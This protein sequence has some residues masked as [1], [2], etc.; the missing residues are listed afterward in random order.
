[1]TGAELV[2]IQPPD[3]KFTFELLKQSSCSVYLTNVTDQYVAF[4][5]KTTSPKKY[6]VKPNI[7]IIKPKSTVDFT[8]IMQAQRTAPV[9]MQCK[10]KF[11]VQSTFIP[12]GKIEDEITPN[13]FLKDEGKYIQENKLRVF[14]I[15][16]PLPPVLQPFNVLKEDSPDNSSTLKEKLLIGLE[17]FPPHTHIEKNEDTK[18]GASKDEPRLGKS[19]EVEIRRDEV[20]E[21]I[22]VEAIETTEV[23]FSKNFEEMK[24]KLGVESTTVD[25]LE[26]KEATFSK[27]FEE[28][29]ANLG[30]NPDYVEHMETTQVTLSKNRDVISPVQTD[31]GDVEP[32]SVEYP[33]ELK[34]KF[35]VEPKS[36]ENVGTAQVL[37]SKNPEEL[38]AKFVAGLRSAEDAETTKLMLSKDIEE[39]KEKLGALNSKLIEAGHTISKL[40]QEKEA[41]A[42]E[43][44]TLMREMVFARKKSGVRKV[45]VGFPPLFV[46]MV[47]LVGLAVGFL[48]RA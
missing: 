47:A 43:K 23:T 39:L 9:D 19:M 45:Q 12:Y 27:P 48:L 37:L 6:C 42:R 18:I 13:M 29:K 32:R 5:V 26:R 1:M 25:D 31:H 15:S 8:V 7:G 14:L 34:A 16:P 28:L 33:E 38:K 17:N 21:S 3:L 30:T 4:K 46:C 20:A 24:A 41:I 44:E 35:G 10:D 36:V 2:V 40:S 11:L 22:P